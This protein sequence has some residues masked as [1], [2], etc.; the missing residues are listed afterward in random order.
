M[1][2]VFA[3]NKLNRNV[4]G[5]A[6]QNCFWH[7]WDLK[8]N[9]RE[10]QLSKTDTAHRKLTRLKPD[11]E[12]KLKANI[13][14]WAAVSTWL[15]LISAV[16][17]LCREAFW[18]LACRCLLRFLIFLTQTRI[19]INYCQFDKSA[20]FLPCTALTCSIFR[21]TTIP[22]IKLK[23]SYMQSN[24]RDERPLNEW[25]DRLSAT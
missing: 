22:Q 3:I 16:E 4:Q 23:D 2:F 9:D 14:S 5:I 19:H 6:K 8:A 7:T 11:I 10:C 1:H 12:S 18:I 13:R 21:R 20:L 17:I 24:V 15:D 25:F